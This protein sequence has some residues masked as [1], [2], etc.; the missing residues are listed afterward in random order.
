MP[1]QARHN[2]RH[3]TTRQLQHWAASVSPAEREAAAARFFEANPAVRPRDAED[4][5]ALEAEREAAILR[6]RTR[7][8]PGQ[9]RTIM[10]NGV[11]LVEPAREWIAPPGAPTA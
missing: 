7:I 10:R 8:I 3:R 5:A 11:T 9:T 2:A 4:A 1:L 6:A